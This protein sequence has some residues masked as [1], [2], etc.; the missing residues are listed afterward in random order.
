MFNNYYGNTQNGTVYI[1]Y[2]KDH[3][4]ANLLADPSIKTNFERVRADA[5]SIMRSYKSLLAK[6]LT[7][8]KKNSEASAKLISLTEALDDETLNMILNETANQLTQGLGQSS[9]GE[10]FSTAQDAS[11]TAKEALAKADYQLL[12]NALDSVISASASFTSSKRALTKLLRKQADA[13]G[14]YAF[15]ETDLAAL[16]N[17]KDQNVLL[18]AQSV[19]AKFHAVL[20]NQGDEKDKQTLVKA[21]STALNQNLISTLLGEGNLAAIIAYMQNQAD[22]S[23]RAELGLSKALGQTTGTKSLKGST[24]QGTTDIRVKNFA[25]KI[26][27]NQN[28]ANQ[29]YYISGNVELSLKTYL[30]EKWQPS[31]GRITIK[32]LTHLVERIKNYYKDCD[33]AIYNTLAYSQTRNTAMRLNIAQDNFRLMRRTLIEQEMLQYLTGGG[34]ALSRTK[35]VQNFSPFIAVNGKVYSTLSILQQTLNSSA[36]ESDDSIA[37]LS[38]ST[39]ANMWEKQEKGEARI[40]AAF[41]RSLKVSAAIDKLTMTVHLNLNNI[42]HPFDTPLI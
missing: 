35:T 5:N 40:D 19:F 24:G 11:R 16:T 26:Q 39:I 37:Y 10:W 29:N 41:R 1:N 23:V 21:F 30:T 32:T 13:S 33:P 18:Q 20:N 28:G 7:I 4:E 12:A 8:A 3:A 14:T 38:A 36:L 9:Y 27:I 22:T 2:H 34:Q 6:Q 31:I 42:I 17:K 15:T 25:T